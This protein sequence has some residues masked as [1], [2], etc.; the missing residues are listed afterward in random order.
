M[1]NLKLDS[2][3]LMYHIS[4]LNQWLDGKDIF[5][6]YVELGLFGGC[7]HRCIFCAFDY[8]KYKP[9]MLKEACLKKF[10]SEA[11]RGGVKAVLFSGEGEPLLHPKAPEFIGFAKKKRI[12][13][14][15]STNGVFLDQRISQKILPDLSWLRV[16]LNSGSAKNYALIH[17]TAAK[18]FQTVL[19]NLKHAV[20][21][22]RKNKY[23]CVLGVQLV[24]LQYNSKE[25]YKLANL[26]RDIGIDYLVIKPFSLH[27]LS[28][29]SGPIR[30]VYNDY[31][32]LQRKLPAY[33]KKGFQIIFRAN[34]FDKLDEIKPY[35][36]CLGFDFIAHI[37]AKGDVFPCN[38]F[39]GRKY[40]VLGSIYKNSFSD[41]LKSRK[42]K[43]ILNKIYRE[44]D[45]HKCR[46]S[47]RQDEANRYL[48]SLQNRVLHHN[49]I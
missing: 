30:E 3:K 15:L 10:L 8:L 18:D 40:F 20:N 27:P 47:C 24:L 46:K 43:I 49:F 33:A 13:V 42:R 21:I 2:H 45:I 41:I 34:S 17:G 39:V 7:N 14:A 32:D 36:K 31:H 35:K 19:N 1:D 38:A 44:W 9:S 5:P 22:K 26:L 25:V 28:I 37:T 6:I 16:S 12:D 23:A 29:N 11:A 4:T 48:W